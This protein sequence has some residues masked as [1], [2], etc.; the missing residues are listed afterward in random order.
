MVTRV[1]RT[2]TQTLSGTSGNVTTGRITG[3]IKSIKVYAEAIMS[4]NAITENCPVPEYILGTV[5]PIVLSAGYTIF[6]PKVVG[7]LN[8]SG[9]ALGDTN[10]TNSYAEMAISAPVKFQVSSGTDTKKWSVEIV[11]EG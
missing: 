2:D 1:E 6:Y 9:A 3:K 10:Q 8:S 11:Y 5:T 4:I 7:N